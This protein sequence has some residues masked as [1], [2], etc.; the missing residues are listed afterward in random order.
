MG[1]RPVC[2]KGGGLACGTENRAPWAGFRLDM[3]GGGR[4]WGEGPGGLC[5]AGGSAKSER[6][7]G[8]G[9]PSCALTWGAGWR[10]EPKTEPRGQFRLEMAANDGG[11]GGGG[12]QRRVRGKE[13]K[14]TRGGVWCGGWPEVSGWGLGTG[15]RDRGAVWYVNRKTGAPGLGLPGWTWMEGVGEG[16]GGCVVRGDGQVELGWGRAGNW[17]VV[18]GGRFGTRETENPSPVGLVSA[19]H[20]GKRGGGGTRGVVWVRGMAK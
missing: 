8:A 3:E 4:G 16:P 17:R 10:V 15:A 5:G 13:K 12:R 18:T 20:G 7:G 19:G 11:R 2:A 6:A 14:K 9:G 1:W